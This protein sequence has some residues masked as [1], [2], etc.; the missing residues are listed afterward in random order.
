MVLHGPDQLFT[1]CRSPRWRSCRRRWI[2]QADRLEPVDHVSNRRI[3]WPD[4]GGGRDVCFHRAAGG[5]A[6]ALKAAEVM[7]DGS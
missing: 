7:G 2:E 4:L 1:A 3:D 6:F 5:P